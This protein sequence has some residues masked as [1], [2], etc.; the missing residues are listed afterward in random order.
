M[1]FKLSGALSACA[2]AL[3]LNG[4]VQANAVSL[5]DLFGGASL[6]AGDKLFDNFT[7]VSQATNDPTRQTPVDTDNIL[8]TALNDG[9]D[10]P[11]PGLAFSILNNEFT[12]AGTGTYTYLGYSF[13]FRVSVI[14]TGKAISG[15]S[16]ELTDGSLGYFLD[17]S[18]DNG[19]LIRET[20]SATALLDDDLGQLSTEFSVLDDV[21]T[22]NL[23][24]TTTFAANPS[25]WVT[26]SLLV[27]ATD[28]GDS[29]RL[30]GFSQRFEQSAVPEPASLGLVALA[31]LAAGAAGRRQARV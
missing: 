23:G 25:V 22:T 30:T 14:P 24:A 12:V 16:L 6:V 26:K 1:K 28:V 8:V 20:V 15:V 9:G 5:T 7:F 10:N 18:N 4:S 31:L 2:L 19:F 27:W 13:G 3:C 17:G 11:G 21:L 29:A